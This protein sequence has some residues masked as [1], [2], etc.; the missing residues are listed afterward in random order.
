L[1]ILRSGLAGYLFVGEGC[2]KLWANVRFHLARFFAACPVYGIICAG[3]CAM[4]GLREGI[5]YDWNLAVVFGLL[6]ILAGVG[7]RHKPKVK[8]FDT[9][10][11]AL[12]LVG[13][14]AF[15]VVYVGV[16][17][18]M[19][20]QREETS[21]F[22]RA[23][24]SLRADEPGELVFYLMG[25][26]QEDVKYAANAERILAPRFVR[27]FDKVVE[28]GESCYFITHEKYFDQLNEG[29]AKRVE[30]VAAGNLGHKESVAFRLV[31]E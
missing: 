22:V 2:G 17:S 13:A 20:Y 21:T 18:P 28:C 30:V 26:D 4:Y 9:G 6:L 15:I 25:P 3:F 19:Y 24:E 29:Q 23:V 12:T 14:L 8:T 31:G 16:V 7:I 10:E 5:G 11:V 1:G 27:E